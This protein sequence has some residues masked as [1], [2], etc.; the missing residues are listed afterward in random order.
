[1]SYQLDKKIK[2][3]DIDPETSHKEIIEYLRNL[4]KNFN[5]KNIEFI[6]SKE[7]PIKFINNEKN[8]CLID[9]LTKVPRP[10]I[11]QYLLPKIEESYVL[12]SKFNQFLIPIKDENENNN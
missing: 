4:A 5:F 12:L 3:F 7:N 6:T 10:K 8:I 11:F 2:F 9:A 1:M